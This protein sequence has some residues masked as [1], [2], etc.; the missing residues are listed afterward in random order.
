M[1]ITHQIIEYV[2]TM[3][4]NAIWLKTLPKTNHDQQLN[5]APLISLE[6]RVLGVNGILQGIILDKRFR[7]WFD[8]V[9]VNAT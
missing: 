5:G 6:N 7:E 4:K 9:K 3:T 1:K 2:I 8:E